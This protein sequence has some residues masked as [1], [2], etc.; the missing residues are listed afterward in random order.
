MKAALPLLAAIALFAPALAQAADLRMDAEAGIGG[1]VRAGTW[2][3]V[4]VALENPGPPITG[5]VVVHFADAGQGKGAAEEPVEL[6][7][8]AKKEIV[9]Y[10]RPR[11]GPQSFEV[12]FEDLRGKVR[13]GPTDVRV[14]AVEDRTAV[15]ALVS[16]G[17]HTDPGLRP[18]ITAQTRI[19]GLDAD[20][21]PESWPALK[22]FDAIVLRDPDTSKLGPARIAALKNWV[23]SGGNLSVVSAEKWRAMDEPSF[24]ELLPVRVKGVRTADAASLPFPFSEQKG[25][26]PVAVTEHLRGRT[27]LATEDGV[28]FIAVGAYGLGRVSFLAADPGALPDVAPDLKAAIWSGILELPAELADDTNNPYYGGQS[29]ESFIS[30]E[31]SRIPPLKPPSVLLVTIL[32]GLYVLVVGPGDYFLLKRIGKLHWTWATYPAAIAVFS[33]MIYLYARLSRSSDMMVRTLALIDASAEPP[34]APSPMRIYGGVYS[35][36]AGRFEVG[37][38]VPDAISG[39]FA[40]ENPAYGMGGGASEYLASGGKHP[41]LTLSIPIWSMAGVEIDSSTT[42]PAPFL[43][44]RAADGAIEVTNTGTEPLAYVGLL[45]DGKM[46]DGGKLEPG[47]HVRLSRL[48]PGKK[49]TELPTDMSQTAFGEEH[50]KED[51]ARIVRV[52]AYATDPPTSSG[53]ADPYY[54]PK[55]KRRLGSLERPRIEKGTPM[56]FAIARASTLPIDV[57]GEAAAGAGLI[58]W[59]R[60]VLASN[61]GDRP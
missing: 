18:L 42:E 48:D 34:T 27:L 12:S 44:D 11:G 23:A 31:L 20:Q 4:R 14:M 35:P 1:V 9:L 8:G 50:S 10:V 30:Q 21:L 47:G 51:L 41:S 45:V 19:V 55:P 46:V 40:D 32:I 60:P 37:V 61:S 29:S 52:F 16:M 54:L 15:V 2:T 26:I 28:P 7:T 58:V 13:A 25:P 57:E 36:R 3:P 24:T 39:G 17:G 59:R 33:G 22:A 6:A 38:K 56:V 49:L 53:T 5:Q 43:V